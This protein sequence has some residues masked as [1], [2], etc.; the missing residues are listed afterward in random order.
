MLVFYTLASNTKLNGVSAT[1]RNDPNPA[2]VI[3]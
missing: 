1:R 3:S 2:S